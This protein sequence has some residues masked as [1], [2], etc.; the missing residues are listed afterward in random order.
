M[1]VDRELIRKES[2]AFF[3][4]GQKNDNYWTKNFMMLYIKK[5]KK[6]SMNLSQNNHFEG[7]KLCFSLCFFPMA[8]RS[9]DP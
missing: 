3:E 2:N 4:R 9:N 7:E 8:G 5:K 1:L 6:N